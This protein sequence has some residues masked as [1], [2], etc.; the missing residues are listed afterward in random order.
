MDR[1]PTSSH[2]NFDRR[3]IFRPLLERLNP[4]AAQHDLDNDELIVVPEH[5]PCDAATPP[6]HLAFANAAEL[7]RGSQIALV[8]GIGSGKSTELHLTQKILNR[9]SD[10]VTILIDL[11]EYTNLNSLQPGAIL[12]AAGLWIYTFLERRL[13]GLP[14]TVIRA[15]GRLKELAFGKTEWVHHD[16]EL[17]DDEDYPFDGL[18]P[19]WSP[20]LMELKLPSL[21]NT[22]EEAKD[23]LLTIC[24][25][26]LKTDSQITLLIDG[27]DRLITA[28]R[29]REF[30]E[31]DLRAL[32]GTKLT[33]IM[34]AP[35]LLWFDRSQFLQDYFDLVRRIPAISTGSSFLKQVLERRGWLTLSGHAELTSI[36]EASGG[37]LRDLLSL[38]RSSAEYAY[39]QNQDRIQ[40]K[41]VR[42]SAIQLGNRYLAGLGQ[43]HFYLLRRLELHKEFPIS[44][45]K[46]LEMLANRQVLEYSDKGRESFAVHPALA[47]VLPKRL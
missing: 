18:Q 17:D 4:I 31:Q 37:V 43:S 42:L 45:E 1:N 9:H 38:A 13:A 14:D 10:A 21:R 32:R 25:P 47:N 30:A 8:G 19:A 41:H 22:V 15:H 28:S 27:L 3:Q 5:D 24:S 20:G 29:F 2:A 39:S 16:P 35:L 11:A 23:L 46:A 6:I 36:I 33:V 26:L 44:H 40:Q 12:A 34:V 7:S